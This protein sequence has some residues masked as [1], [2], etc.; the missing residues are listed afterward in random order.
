MRTTPSQTQGGCR[1]CNR[2]QIGCGCDTAGVMGDG[3]MD[4]PLASGQRGEETSMTVQ[5]PIQTSSL[6]LIPTRAR[7]I[8]SPRRSLGS[9]VSG[10]ALCAT[11]K[12]QAGADCPL[13]GRPGPIAGQASSNEQAT[14]SR[15][16]AEISTTAWH[17]LIL[18]PLLEAVAAGT[19]TPEDAGLALHDLRTMLLKRKA[20]TKPPKPATLRRRTGT[21]N[22]NRPHAAGSSNLTGRFRRG[23]DLFLPR[24]PSE[25]R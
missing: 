17:E 12:L 5:M 15:Q 3:P 1:V 8:L 25:T 2:G 24:D 23:R 20:A 16:P 4:P 7:R 22:A 10:C 14:T 9:G 19:A 11:T 21:V 18:L 6:Q 13:C